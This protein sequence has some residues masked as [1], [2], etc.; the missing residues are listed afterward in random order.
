MGTFKMK[1][2]VLVCAL[3]I[4]VMAYA[5]TEVQELGNDDAAATLDAENAMEHAD[6]DDDLGEDED[7]GRR[8][9]AFLST[10][11]SFTLS[12]GGGGADNRAGNGLEDDE[13]EEDM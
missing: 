6:E 13:M 5:V 9:G 8:G 10:T 11:G 12:S 7:Q 1:R 2:F 3:S 4:F